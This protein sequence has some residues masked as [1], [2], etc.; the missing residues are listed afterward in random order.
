MKS[1]WSWRVDRVAEYLVSMF[2]DR[3]RRG[4]DVV[5]VEERCYSWEI[6]FRISLSKGPISV[7][8]RCTAVKRSELSHFDPL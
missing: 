2:G 6:V 7:V 8:F 5:A 3:E 1:S 4:I